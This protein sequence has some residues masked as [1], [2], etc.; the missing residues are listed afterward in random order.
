MYVDRSL[1]GG[2]AA[3][4]ALTAQGRTSLTIDQPFYAL[5]S[6]NGSHCNFYF[7]DTGRFQQN[8]FMLAPHVSGERIHCLNQA[9][10]SN[11]D[12][13]QF[14]LEQYRVKR[15]REYSR[16]RQA[17]YQAQVQHVGDPVRLQRLVP[18]PV[19]IYQHSAHCKYLYCYINNK[20][21]ILGRPQYVAGWR[22]SPYSV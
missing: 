6:L 3:I 5:E 10:T 9:I 7:V 21:C 2:D 20:M 1:E 12:L 16:C 22:P 8:A 13:I 17:M 11:Y 19:I 15:E 4:D 14:I 18:V